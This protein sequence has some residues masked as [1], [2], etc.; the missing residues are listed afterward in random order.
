MNQS[1]SPSYGG[2]KDSTA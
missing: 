1:I 2:E